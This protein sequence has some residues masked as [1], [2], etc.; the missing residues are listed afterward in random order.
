MSWF[1]SGTSA[2]RFWT[3]C[4]PISA[5]RKKKKKAVNRAELVWHVCRMTKTKTRRYSGKVPIS[6]LEAA[7]HSPVH[8]K[9]VNSM[10]AI[11]GWHKCK[12]KRV[13]ETGNLMPRPDWLLLFNT[14]LEAASDQWCRPCTFCPVVSFLYLALLVLEAFWHLQKL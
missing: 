14:F 5:E 11:S 1:M 3:F 13:C 4:H 6:E 2:D 8:Y 7:A 12:G 10:C 9:L